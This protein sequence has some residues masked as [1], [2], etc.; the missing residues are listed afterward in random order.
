MGH[1]GE[2]RPV[3][4]GPPPPAEPQSPG[5]GKNPSLTFDKELGETL[6][7]GHGDFISSVICHRA[8]VDGEDSLL[9]DILKHVPEAK[10]SPQPRAW[11]RS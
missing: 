1:S 2:R 6:L 10:T 8:L 11:S 7:V 4:S 5:P 9:T 3:F